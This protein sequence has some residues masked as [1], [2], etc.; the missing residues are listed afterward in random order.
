MRIGKIISSRNI[1]SRFIPH[2]SCPQLH[3][4]QKN[5]PFSKVFSNRRR[6]QVSKLSLLIYVSFHLELNLMDASQVELEDT[7]L[8][9]QFTEFHQKN[10]LCIEIAINL[11]WKRN[12]FCMFW[13]VKKRLRRESFD[14]DNKLC[15]QLDPDCFKLFGKKTFSVCE[16]NRWNCIEISLTQFWTFFFH[17]KMNFC[18]LAERKVSWNFDP[19]LKYFAENI[20]Q[21]F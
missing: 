11:K 12:F 19:K 10:L 7:I 1:I 17:R 21:E 2:P 15:F 16:E 13:S 3:S 4:P 18:S 5:N 20:D 14:D 8:C 6:R 9:F